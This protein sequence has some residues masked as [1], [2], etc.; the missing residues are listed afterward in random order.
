MEQTLQAMG[1]TVGSAFAYFAFVLQIISKFSF[2]SK[3]LNIIKV[4]MM[5]AFYAFVER[6]FRYLSQL[7]ILRYPVSNLSLTELELERY[8]FLSVALQIQK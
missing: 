5:S 4:N 3:F 7:T 2:H 6:K 1:N 8:C